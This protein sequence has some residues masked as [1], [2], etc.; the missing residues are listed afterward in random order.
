MMHEQTPLDPQNTKRQRKC[1]YSLKILIVL[2]LTALRVAWHWV[3]SPNIHHTDVQEGIHHREGS[4]RVQQHED[5][6]RKY[7]E[8]SYPKKRRCLAH[9]AQSRQTDKHSWTLWGGFAR[10]VHED[11]YR[12]LLIHVRRSRFLH[13]GEEGW[14]CWRC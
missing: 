3:D 10:L 14:C 9:D 2:L 6:Q 8:K 13:G 1:S 4:E 12:Y 7:M 11:G 5:A